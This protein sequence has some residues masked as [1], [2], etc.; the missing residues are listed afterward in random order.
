M[1]C[2]AARE[3][4]TLV[5]YFFPF[6]TIISCFDKCFV[7]RNT[8]GKEVSDAVVRKIHMSAMLVLFYLRSGKLEPNS[9]KKPLLLTLMTT[10]LTNFAKFVHVQ[11]SFFP[12][13][14]T[15]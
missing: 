15:E 6:Q 3:K 12:H 5:L 7:E 2:E 9:V 4:S 13:H 10:H 14:A 11:V 8:F 1:S